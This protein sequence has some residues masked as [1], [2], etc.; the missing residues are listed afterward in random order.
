MRSTI[1]AGVVMALAIGVSGCTKPPGI[2]TSPSAAAERQL[3]FDPNLRLKWPGPPSEDSQLLNNE[4]GEQKHYSAT[5]TDKRPEGVVIFS[6]FVDEYPADAVK[7]ADPEELLTATVF[8]FKADE[9]SQKKFAHGPQKYP[10]FDIL[11]QSDGKFDRKLVVVAG[12]RVYH[13]AVT[14]TKEEW[15]KAPEVQAFFDSLSLDK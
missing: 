2:G 1:L 6:A 8:A 7:Q 3:T 10:G 12:R 13:I 15:L 5:F 11:S 9:V 4:V 14:S